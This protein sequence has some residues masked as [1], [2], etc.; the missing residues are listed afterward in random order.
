MAFSLALPWPDPGNDVCDVPS[1][2]SGLA[3]LLHRLK[4]KITFNK[5]Y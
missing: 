5:R 4:E 3:E 2:L 1:P